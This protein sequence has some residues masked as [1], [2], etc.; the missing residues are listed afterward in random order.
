MLHL[1]EQLR[2]LGTSK[3]QI[4]GAGEPLP[5]REHLGGAAEDPQWRRWEWWGH[6]FPKGAAVGV[7]D[8]RGSCWK[9]WRLPQRAAVGSGDYQ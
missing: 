6:S 8:S 3:L 9:C 7:W 5:T 2:V 4:W 1:R